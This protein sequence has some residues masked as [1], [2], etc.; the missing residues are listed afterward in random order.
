MLL[1]APRLWALLCLLLVL[2]LATAQSFRV[3]QRQDD[4]ATVTTESDAEPTNGDDADKT[5][6]GL[7]TSE[8]DAPKSKTE[9]DRKASTTDDSKT[10]SAAPPA[11]TTITTDGPL[12]PSSL[13]NG[14]DSQLP[15]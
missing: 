12:D 5:S 1:K 7:E 11:S 9:S 8:T 14:T 2:Q 13:R 15:F 3:L 10:S 4:A 6:T